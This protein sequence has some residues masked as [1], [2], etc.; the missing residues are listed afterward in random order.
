M[1]LKV[2]PSES[3]AKLQ[4]F[5]SQRLKIS[6]RAAKKKIDLGHLRLNGRMER[7]GSTALRGGD[8][9]E[10][11][12]EEQEPIVIYEDDHI[13]VINKPSGLLST[14]TV[15]RLD[16]DTSGLLIFAKTDQA[17]EVLELAFRERRVNKRYL[18]YVLGNPPDEGEIN[19]R[20]D[21]KEAS[22]RFK[23]IGPHLLYCYPK[24]GRTHQ[25]R[26]HL[27]S[28]GH[29]IAGDTKYGPRSAY[30]R[31]LLHAEQLIFD[32]PITGVKLILKAPIPK[33]LSDAISDR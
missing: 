18:A 24:T 27:A 14:S 4:N 1:K 17:Q 10:L 15:H 31:Q 8:K 5:L 6:V 13:R 11:L 33:D 7:F 26:I 28:I 25:I 16:R 30:P 12:F 9:I 29:P 2:A 20:I 32:H 19:Q 21:K 3:G 23:K 22:T